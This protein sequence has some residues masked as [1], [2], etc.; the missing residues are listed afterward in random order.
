MRNLM[1]KSLVVIVGLATVVALT[2]GFGP[3]WAQTK[4]KPGWNL[5]SVQQDI[6]I[7]RQSA[8][9]ADRQLPIMRDREVTNYITGVGMKLTAVAGGPE[10]PWRF[11]VVDTKDINA[12][13]LPGGFVYVNRGLIETSENEAQL[14]GVMAHEI[15]HVELR[16]GTNQASKALFAQAPLA[17][18]GGALGQGVGAL[19]AKYGLSFG[20]NSLF[21][22]YSRTAETQADV[23]GVQ[24]L[25]DARYNTH[26]MAAFFEILNRESKSRPPQF[27]S[28][29]PNPDNRIKRI[30]QEI[31]KLRLSRNPT[32][33]TARFRQIRAMLKGMPASP[34]RNRDRNRDTDRTP[35]GGRGGRTPLPSN[36]SRVYEHPDRTYRFA[37]PANWR[38]YQE[39]GSGVTI[40]PEGGVDSNRGDIEYGVLVNI[41]DLQDEA[42]HRRVSLDDATHQLIAFIQRDNP[43]LS[44]RS[45]SERR[46]TLGGR[47]AIAVFL[48]GTPSNRRTERVRLVARMYG[49]NLLYILFIAPD[50]EYGDYE[51]AFD[52]VL[53]S[54]EVY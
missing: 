49:G 52:R 17:I 21:L 3:A 6:E 27:F 28:D 11:R 15:S 24:I 51:R 35:E 13:A 48:T 43:Y 19:F 39:Q 12:F 18:L 36:D 53:N 45:N 30:D 14:A 25:N 8:E 46:G 42:R 10:Y 38:V 33:D 20:L 40:S 7:G 31:S 2:P 41:F 37:Y 26:E 32:T 22:K 44:V 4:L 47:E 1:K 29:H 54:F 50:E 23:R 34:S 5:F 9:E 16:H